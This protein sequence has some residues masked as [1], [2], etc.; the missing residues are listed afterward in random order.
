MLA[1]VIGLLLFLGVHS[2]RLFAAQWRTRQV[3]KMGLLPFKGAYALLSLIGLVLV[4]V[5]HVWSQPGCGFRPSGLAIWL[6]C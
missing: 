6:L 5:R 2:T 3:A 1:L 4:T